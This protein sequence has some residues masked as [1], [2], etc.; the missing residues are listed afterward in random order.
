MTDPVQFHEV[1][2]TIVNI[3]NLEKVLMASNDSSPVPEI[4]SVHGS[5]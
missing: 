2:T 3:K 1:F 5:N 4:V